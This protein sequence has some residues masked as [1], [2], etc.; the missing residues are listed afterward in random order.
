M[1]ADHKGGRKKVSIA[2]K[3]EQVSVGVY[4]KNSERWILE[5]H[6]DEFNALKES[7]SKKLLKG[8]ENILKINQ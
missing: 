8:I 3:K 4:I 2:D 1:K 6:S 5:K 7:I